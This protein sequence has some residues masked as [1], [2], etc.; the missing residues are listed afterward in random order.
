LVRAP[1]T[2]NTNLG[3]DDVIDNKGAG[4]ERE[5]AA[6]SQTPLSD[7][8]S[9]E[10]GQFE[11]VVSAM[12]GNKIAGNEKVEIPHE[13]KAMEKHYCHR[14]KAVG[15]LMKDFRINLARDKGNKKEL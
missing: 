13:N 9:G 3:T 7:E 2:F 12:F 15:R 10:G 6:T 4:V 5:G 1:R 8:S 14:C 11:Q